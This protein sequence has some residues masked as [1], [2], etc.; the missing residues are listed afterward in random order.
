MTLPESKCSGAWTAPV[1]DV[2]VKVCL[3]MEKFRGHVGAVD[4]FRSLAGLPATSPCQC[5]LMKFTVRQYLSEANT[6]IQ[7]RVTN[8]KQRNI[9]LRCHPFLILFLRLRFYLGNRNWLCTAKG[10]YVHR[11]FVLGQPFGSV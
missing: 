5:Q 8:L 2:I 6:I 4:D 10:S 3:S 9:F 11:E 1:S 7:K